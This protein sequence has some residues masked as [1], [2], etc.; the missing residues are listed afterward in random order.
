MAHAGGMAHGRENSIEAVRK[1]LEYGADIIELDVRKSRDGIIF[2]YHGFGMFVFYL[3]FL[4]RF[5]RFSTVKRFIEV[6]TLEEILS[7]IDRDCV[8]YLDVKDSNTDPRA[9]FDLCSR[10]D[11]SFWVGGLRLKFLERASKV[12]VGSKYK[13]C[14]SWGFF[15]RFWGPFK[16]ARRLNLVPYKLFPWQCTAKKIAA[17]RRA[18]MDFFIE[19][20]LISNA[21]YVELLAKYGTPWIALNDV[22]DVDH[23]GIVHRSWLL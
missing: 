18:N 14:F 21:R 16:A 12:F 2:C 22:R 9:L 13:L 5:V 1:S 19:P 17:L 8:V 7:A 4:L 3:A 10:F 15:L 6:S 23:P 11:F 20:M